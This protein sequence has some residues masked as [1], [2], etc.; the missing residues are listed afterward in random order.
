MCRIWLDTLML[1]I[2]MVFFFKWVVTT[3]PTE[4]RILQCLVVYYRFTS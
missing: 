2:I 1:G 3:R 4:R